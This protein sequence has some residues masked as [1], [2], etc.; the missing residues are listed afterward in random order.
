MKAN[1]LNG[2][3]RG[4]AKNEDIEFNEEG[5]RYKNN[6]QEKK[7]EDDSST[8]EGGNEIATSGRKI[9][10]LNYSKK[11]VNNQ[12]G[13][14]NQVEDVERDLLKGNQQGS[15]NKE[16]SKDLKE[17][18]DSSYQVQKEEFKGAKEELKNT[19]MNEESREGS[20]DHNIR[21]NEKEVEKGNLSQYSNTDRT[22][23]E[24]NIEEKKAKEEE[25]MNKMQ[26]GEQRYDP[27]QK[28]KSKDYNDIQSS[29][30]NNQEIKFNRKEKTEDKSENYP[31][32]SIKHKDSLTYE[33]S[34]KDEPK[35]VSDIQEKENL[36]KGNLEK[37]NLE[38]DN[39]EKSY[40]EKDNREKDHWEKSSTEKEN[41]EK[42]NREN[43]EKSDLVKENREKDN[44]EKTSFSDEES[45][46]LK[47]GKSEKDKFSYDKSDK[48]EYSQKYQ[49][50]TESFEKETNFDERNN[51]ELDKVDERNN[52]KIKY[53]KKVI[54]NKEAA[55]DNDEDRNLKLKEQEATSDSKNQDNL[56]A[57]EGEQNENKDHFKSS[58]NVES[59]HEDSMAPLYEIE[60]KNDK[61]FYHG[62]DEASMFQKRLEEAQKFDSIKSQG[63]FSKQSEKMQERKLRKEDTLKAGNILKFEQSLKTREDEDAVNEG[64]RKTETSD[65]EHELRSSEEISDY[66]DDHSKELYFLKSKKTDDYDKNRAINNE[67]EKK[68]ED[69]N[70]LSKKYL[71]DKNND[72]IP[73]ES[74][75][76]EEN[77][78]KSTESM[79]TDS[80][81][82]F[83]ENSVHEPKYVK[84]AT[85][86]RRLLNL[87]EMDHDRK[88]DTRDVS[89]DNKLVTD[90]MTTGKCICC[91]KNKLLF[92]TTLLKMS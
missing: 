51:K 24:K 22:G 46:N 72:K 19:N 68:D 13:N 8:K 73:E 65:S 43:R 57:N 33:K 17:D 49:N 26:E 71:T 27:I 31:Q 42:N 77:S 82:F 63:S 34:E 69:L 3:E 56:K 25:D 85:G 7:G 74:R 58:R 36:E 60:T 2:K 52:K 80:S 91:C 44:R 70:N 15:E 39:Q 5:H 18:K 54:N 92:F 45:S 87:H 40:R 23:E 12:D 64:K 79:R 30:E 35:R 89:M 62:N 11:K 6:M 28:K 90:E 75:R 66:A 4:D 84:E 41:Q 55:K 16:F 14:K 81:N 86:S 37:D 78:D 83:S 21:K 9:K 47:S 29:K 20:I 76:Y 50:H 10:N 38:K 53:L 61:N 1:K 88:S 59:L 48:S 67:N 32:D